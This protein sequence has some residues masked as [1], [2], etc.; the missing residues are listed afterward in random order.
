MIIGIDFGTT[1]T[2][3]CLL[4]DGE[5]EVLSFGEAQ[6][7]RP[8]VPSIVALK[9]RRPDRRYFGVAAKKMAGMPGCS[10]FRNFKM[11][12]G[13]PEEVRRR[14]WETDARPEELVREFFARLFDLLAGEHGLKP[15]KAVVTIPEIWQRHNLQAKREMLVNCFQGFALEQTRVE[16]EPIAAASYYL[17]RFKRK[18]GR[19]F[20][21]HLLVCDCGGG[22]MDFCLAR[23]DDSGAGVPTV[24]VLERAG[25]GMVGDTL[26][27]AGVAF[28]QAVVDR[29]FPGLRAGDPRLYHKRLDEFEDGKISFTGSVSEGLEAYR[30]S[31]ETMEGEEL[32][33]FETPIE[34]AA[35]AASFDRLILPDIEK[36]LAEIRETLPRHGVREHDPDRFRVLLV[37]GFSSFY[38][39]Q[40]A[41]KSMFGSIAS[42]DKRFEDIFSRQDRAL[43][44]AKG[45]ALIAGSLTRIVHTCPLD[46]GVYAF[47]YCDG[48]VRK[49]YYRILEKGVDVEAYREVVWYQEQE[50]RVERESDPLTCFIQSGKEP[51][52]LI[53][54]DR[55]LAAVLPEEC[56]PGK[57]QV[58]FS[59]DENLLFIFHARDANDESRQRSTSLGTLI[60]QLP[61]GLFVDRKEAEESS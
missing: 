30:R 12:L 38:L 40:E 5:P 58:G 26:G 11:L 52:D 19:D 54:E 48:K 36:A 32:F 39:V 18:Y 55:V 43:A 3:V 31:P 45:A 9:D 21:G 46:V 41:V 35:L 29:L 51:L 15:E 33:P 2:A 47:E 27:N 61:R 4:K 20:S 22:T 17:H 49:N 50:F 59:I 14:F 6:N 7:A 23:V 8:Y 1:N 42:T 24:T 53:L 37:G 34:A 56:L 10:V 57:I 25:N 28:D 16:S 60:D 13:E 44:I